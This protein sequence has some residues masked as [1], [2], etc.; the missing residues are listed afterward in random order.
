MR[1]IIR[2]PR[3]WKFSICFFVRETLSSRASQKAASEIWPPQITSFPL[4]WNK[5][6][7]GCTQTKRH[8]YKRMHTSLFELTWDLVQRALQTPS[9]KTQRIV[10]GSEEVR[11][12]ISWCWGLQVWD[13]GVRQQNRVPSVGV[14]EDPRL[15]FY[16]ISLLSKLDFLSETFNSREKLQCGPQ[17]YF[18]QQQIRKH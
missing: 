1:E 18:P 12:D 5:T 4:M 17:Q 2:L 11:L 13:R 9:L 16:R 14:W 10:W 8:E 7:K 3:N 6:S 15:T